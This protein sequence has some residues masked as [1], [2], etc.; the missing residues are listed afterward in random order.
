M[1]GESSVMVLAEA[2]R[3]HSG[4]FTRAGWIKEKR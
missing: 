4:V 1:A 2:E 3:D